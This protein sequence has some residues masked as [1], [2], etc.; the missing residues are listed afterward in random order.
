MTGKI[1]AQLAELGIS[2]P[3]APTPAANYVPYVITG[4]LVYVSGQVSVMNGELI[5]GK[6]GDD[7]DIE[8]GQKAARN[9]ALNLLAQ[10][11]A[12]CGGDLDRVRRVVKLGGFVNATPDFTGPP[13][14]INGAS[15]V[16]VDIFGDV[17]RHARFAV[18]VASLPSGAA[19]EIDGVFEIE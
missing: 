15:D 1:D 10:L 16:L 17:G 9:C 7:V 11:K 13:Q 3:E 5:A 8:T 4:N 12:A 19:V 18:A 14:I 6:L 2:L